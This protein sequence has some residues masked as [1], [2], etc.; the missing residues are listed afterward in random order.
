M[1]TA[2]GWDINIFVIVILKKVVSD[3]KYKL[4]LNT[5]VENHHFSAKVNIFVG[6]GVMQKES[7]LKTLIHIFYPPIFEHLCTVHL[8]N[9]PNNSHCLNALVHHKHIYAQVKSAPCLFFFSIVYI[10]F[11]FH[12]NV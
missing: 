12:K 1:L 2:T 10:Q 4:C 8:L 6:R 7:Y 9:Q 11:I 3:R 5:F